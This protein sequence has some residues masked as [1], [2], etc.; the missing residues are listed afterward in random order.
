M[1]LHEFCPL[2]EF[3]AVLQAL[4]P[5]Q[6]LPPPH[7]TLAPADATDA[8]LPTANRIAAEATSRRFVVMSNSVGRGTRKP[9]TQR[10]KHEPLHARREGGDGSMLRE[11]QWRE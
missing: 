7:F 4:V 1:P 3:W 11:A 8:A 9:G 10:R 2:Q 6:E 5:L